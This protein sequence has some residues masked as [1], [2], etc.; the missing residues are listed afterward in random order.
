MVLPVPQL[1]DL[2]LR[3]GTRVLLRADFNVPLRDGHI[4]DDLRITASAADDRVAAR[5]GTRRSCCARTSGG[6]RAR[7][8]RGTRSRRSRLGSRPCS[9]ARS[10]S[11]RRSWA[12]TRSASPQSLEPGGVMMLENLRF[13]PGEEACDPA[14]CTNL[15]EFGDV[16]VNDAFG[17]AHRAHAS[18]VGPPYVMPAAAGRLL[19]REV[20]VLG[21]LLD[22]PALAVRRHPRRRQ[23]QR[24]ARRDRR[25][26]GALRHAADRR[27]DGVHLPRRAGRASRRLARRDRSG[28]PLPHAHGDGAHQDSDRR[29]RRAADDRRRRSPSRRGRRD[30]RRMEGLRHRTRDGRRLRRHD[31]RRGDCALERSDGRVRTGAVRGRHAHRRGGRRRVSRVHGRRWRRQRVGRAPD[32]TRRIASTTCRRAAAPRSS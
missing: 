1:E 23:G 5:R 21:T 4:D 18:I 12:S 11:R 15:S 31:R 24:Q 32:G 9:A 7:S 25:I 17:A 8:T 26:V 2:R 22:A 16:Y 3:R 6:R 27:R 20:E 14:F 29:R 30:P 28:R 10:S 19:A 13:E